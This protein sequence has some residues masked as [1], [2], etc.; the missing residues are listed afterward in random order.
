MLMV[1]LQKNWSERT[2]W[3]DIDFDCF[4]LQWQFLCQL[5]RHSGCLCFGVVIVRSESNQNREYNQ[6]RSHPEYLSTIFKLLWALWSYYQLDVSC[7]WPIYLLSMLRQVFYGSKRGSIT[8]SRSLIDAGPRE[9]FVVVC[10]MI[11]MIGIGLYPKMVTQIYEV[12]T[13]AV[14]EHIHQS[15]DYVATKST[16]WT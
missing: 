9:I 12:R 5:S 7:P 4:L 6:V 8:H 14:V 10:L 1:R 3:V 11:P 2:Y 13:N 15:R 16:L